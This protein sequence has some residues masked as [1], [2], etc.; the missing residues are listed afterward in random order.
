MRQREEQRPAAA[1]GGGTPAS[2]V[3]HVAIAPEALEP[4]ILIFAAHLLDEN[5]LD[6]VAY[7]VER[8][9]T[10]ILPVFCVQEETSLWK[11]HRL[12]AFALL[13]RE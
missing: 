8:L 3:L 5:P 9:N 1:D 4:P 10:G 2:E 12:R 13:D 7:L 6:L 11:D